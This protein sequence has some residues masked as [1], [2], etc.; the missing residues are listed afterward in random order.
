MKNIFFFAIF[1]LSA[2]NA[3]AYIDP[4]TGSA[5]I[6]GIL[7]LIAAGFVT[8]KIYWLKLV[9]FFEDAKKFFIKKK[10]DS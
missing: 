8:I 5:F 6:Q 10:L 2:N 3:Y 7:A 9:K 4:G 1:I